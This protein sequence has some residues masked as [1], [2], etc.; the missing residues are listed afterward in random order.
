MIVLDFCLFLSWGDINVYIYT[1][2]YSYLR[3]NIYIYI[4]IHIYICDLCF[5]NV[6][7][8]ISWAKS[9]YQIYNAKIGPFGSLPSKTN[10]FEPQKSWRFR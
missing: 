1:D 3:I 2:A 8:D 9:H 7:I 4:H 5:S 6:R 10:M